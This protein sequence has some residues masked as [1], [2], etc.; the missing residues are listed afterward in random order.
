LGIDFAAMAI[1][2]TVTGNPSAVAMTGIVGALA[3]TL[4]KIVTQRD[5]P[6]PA[7]R[8]AYAFHTGRVSQLEGGMITTVP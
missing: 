2:Y 5:Q 6:R 8:I 3:K 1:A 7:A 4:V